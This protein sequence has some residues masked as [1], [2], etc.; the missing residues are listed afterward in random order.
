M[1]EILNFPQT[2]AQLEIDV[3]IYYFPM[4]ISVSSSNWQYEFTKFL[5]S[6]AYSYKAGE[7]G[8]FLDIYRIGT[9]LEYSR[10]Q[11]V[12]FFD[13][14]SLGIFAFEPEAKIIKSLDTTLKIHKALLKTSGEFIRLFG[15]STGNLLSQKTPF[16]IIETYGLETTQWNAEHL[17]DWVSPYIIIYL[18]C[19]LKNNNIEFSI[20]DDDLILLQNA[21]IE[22][23]HTIG[24]SLID[25]VEL[26]VNI[27][28]PPE[29]LNFS[30]YM[31]SI[32]LNLPSVENFG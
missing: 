5:K 21:D 18:D 19:W 11:E 23:T 22:V 12:E 26:G 32:S 16:T 29:I 6:L 17:E 24:M 27:V 3:G 14:R 25:L 2:K 1:T 7:G 15:F 8:K 28:F 20:E 4:S 13:K 10:K 9:V 31:G 30:F